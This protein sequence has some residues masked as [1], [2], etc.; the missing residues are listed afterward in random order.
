MEQSFQQNFDELQTA[1]D[2]AR[3]QS[4][5][6]RQEVQTLRLQLSALEADVARLTASEAL[7]KERSEK[8]TEQVGRPC[9]EYSD[10]A[11]RGVSAAGSWRWLMPLQQP[12]LTEG[13]T[14][15]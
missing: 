15:W 12:R 7:W 2:E 11:H 8:A 10:V 4:S 9:N 3:Q 14:G 6:H 1:R 13:C 5:Q